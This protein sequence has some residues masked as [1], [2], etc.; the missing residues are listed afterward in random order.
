MSFP[1][2]PSLES[3]TAAAAS[4]ATDSATPS[5]SEEEV[6]TLFVSG[7]P[8]DVT[9]R[10][11]YLIFNRCEGFDN[12][13]LYATALVIAF[14]SWNAA[15]DVCHHD[16]FSRYY[17]NGVPVGFVLFVSVAT[18]QAS[19]LQMN[20]FALD[21]D[22]TKQIR[23]EFAKKNSKLRRDR[24]YYEDVAAGITPSQAPMGQP[25]Q[26]VPQQYNMHVPNLCAFSAC[27]HAVRRRYQ[28]QAYASH[29]A[30][31]YGAGYDWSQAYAAPAFG[32]VAGPS[33]TRNPPSLTLHVANLSPDTT[34]QELRSVFSQCPGF[35]TLRVTSLRG[36]LVAFVEFI[37]LPSSSMG[38][39]LWQ[40]QLLRPTDR[41][42]PR[43]LFARA[44]LWCARV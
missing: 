12:S 15:D 21:P 2:L 32:A 18:A 44:D 5:T 23:V 26:L 41:F 36:S 34:D 39:Q 24:K 8:S 4:A 6:R 38:M 28:G 40:G 16:F 37:D 43:L 13:H 25:P 20:G 35:K 17:K 14:F 11:L 19:M 31:A 9:E 10:E 30:S 33:G 1:Q 22:N 27:S 3:H 29:A 7:L 42:A